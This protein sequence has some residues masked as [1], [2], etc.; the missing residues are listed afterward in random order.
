MCHFLLK[1]SILSIGLILLLTSCE[2]D[3]ETVNAL[4]SKEQVNVEEAREVQLLYSDSARVRVRVQ[5]PVM[6]RH[7]D[8]AQP[9]EEFPD[10]IRVEFMQPGS[11]RSNGELTANYAIRYENQGKIIVRDDVVW[12]SGKGDELRTSELTWD[13]QKKKMYTNHF[14]KITKPDEEFFGYGFEADQDFNHWKITNPTGRMMVEGL[15]DIAPE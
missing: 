15:E 12:K 8:H 2:N 1:K 3:L 13:D 9:K 6:L 4:F 7:I 5:G 10:G 11:G 14:V